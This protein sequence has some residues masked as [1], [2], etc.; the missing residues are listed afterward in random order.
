MPQT[1]TV[2]SRSLFVNAVAW[3]ALLMALLICG[4]ASSAM[5]MSSA[6]L[7]GAP[8]DVAAALPALMPWLQGLALLLAA[9]TSAA[10]VGL[11]RRQDWARRALIGLLVLAIV[12]GLAGLGLQQAVV[13]WLVQGTLAHAA[14]PQAVAP[15]VAGFVVATR[16]MSVLVMLGLCGLLAVV[17]WRLTQ[18]MV[19]QEFAAAA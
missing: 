18:P 8:A 14:L 6:M 17:A 13:Q 12:L 2:G 15:V 1:F 19:R 5:F 11:L 9:L 7:D 3:L 10:A 4:S 16:S